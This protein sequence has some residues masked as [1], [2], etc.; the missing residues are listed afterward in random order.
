MDGPLWDQP[1]WEVSVGWSRWGA[2]GWGR[3][4]NPSHLSLPLEKSSVPSN[5]TLPP[6]TQI[7]HVNTNA[8]LPCDFN[9]PMGYKCCVN[10]LSIFCFNF[11]AFKW[12]R[13]LFILIHLPPHANAFTHPA[14]SHDHPFSHP[15][16]T[17][18][19]RKIPVQHLTD[20]W[21][22]R[23]GVANTTPDRLCIQS[24]DVYTSHQVLIWGWVNQGERQGSVQITVIIVTGVDHEWESN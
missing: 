20:F 2:N 4:L 1:W 22:K 18:T 5:N 16:V 14:R 3:L 21:E 10:V 6:R 24:G 15:S 8:F 19:E 13:R 11:G 9:Q 23:F 17:W 12:I 7:S